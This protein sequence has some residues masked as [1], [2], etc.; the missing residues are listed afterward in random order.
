MQR[1]GGQW[2]LYFDTKDLFQQ[3]GK[4]I[5]VVDGVAYHGLPPKLR[6]THAPLGLQAPRRPDAAGPGTEQHTAG[7][8]TPVP[9]LKG[10]LLDTEDDLY[11][12]S[13]CN[14]M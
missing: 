6:L 4:G 3:A 14:V 2:T 5:I 1:S 12:P 13:F 8:S 9:P 10:G 7:K 11:V